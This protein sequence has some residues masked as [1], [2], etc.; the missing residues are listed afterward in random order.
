[1]NDASL[2]EKIDKVVR[3]H[4]AEVQPQAMAAA[5]RAFVCTS[6]KVRRASVS[7]SGPKPVKRRDAALVAEL[8]ERL[9]ALLPSV[10]RRL[11]EE[12]KVRKQVPDA[13]VHPLFPDKGGLLPWATTDNGDTLYWLTEGPPEAWPTL[14]NY[15]RSSEYHRYNVGCVGFIAGWSSGELKPTPFD[16]V[17]DPEGP[18]KNFNAN[19]SDD[20]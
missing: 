13:I 16:G 1:M 7:S 20:D 6:T 17:F 11:D 2:T 10:G 19:P 12:R 4:L 8:S 9:Q 14:I 3:D 15:S 5:Q 18:S